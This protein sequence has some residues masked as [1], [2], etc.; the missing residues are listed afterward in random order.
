MKLIIVD[1]GHFHA[2]LLQKEMHPSLARRVSVYAPSGPELLDYLD[3][4]SRFNTRRDQPTAWELDV[5]CS[6]D[7]MRSMLRDRAG[8][9]VLFTGR[10]QKKIGRILESLSAGLHVLADKPWIISSSDMPR[11]EQALALAEAHRLGL[12]FVEAN[13]GA[14]AAR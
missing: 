7:P 12:V 4:I 9:V 3:R 2:A 8:N 11:L 6:S 14:L 10:N 1:P 5:R 13:A